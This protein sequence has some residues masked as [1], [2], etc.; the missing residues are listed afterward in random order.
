M[1]KLLRSWV[2]A[3]VLGAMPLGAW[4]QLVVPINPFNAAAS[5]TDGTRETM[6]GTPAIDVI[7]L[8]AVGPG[9]PLRFGNVIPS[10]ER[11]TLNG[12]SLS[13]GTEYALDYAAGVMYLKVAQK[14]GD[15]LT[16]SYRYGEKPVGNTVGV[17][18]GFAGMKFD[19]APGGLKMLMG[20]GIA[21]RAADGS[22]M[23]SNVYGVNNTMKFAGGKV[24]GLFLVGERSR[25]DN[26][27]GLTFAAQGGGQASTQEQGNSSLIVQQFQSALLGGEFEAD[28]QDVSKNFAAF[29]QVRDAGYDQ[30]TVDAMAKERGLNRFSAALRN[31]KMGGGLSFG[32]AFKTVGEGSSGIEWRSMNLAQGDVTKGNGLRLQV[33]SQKVDGD[34]NRIRDLREGDREQLLKERGMSRESLSGEIA[35]QFGKLSFSS[36]AV[37]DDA[38]GQGILR[39]EVTLDTARLKLQ[40]GDQD[41]D[42]GFGRMG[43]LL[44]QEQALYGRELGMRRQWLALESSIL[45]KN[46]PFA[47]NQRLLGSDQ[48][49][50][51]AREASLKGGAWSLNHASR[52]ADAGF[53]QIGAMSD[54]EIDGNLRAIAKMYGQNVEVRPEDRS[55]FFGTAGIGREYTRLDAQPFKGWNASF[56]HLQ[57]RGQTDGAKVSNLTVTGPKASLN[58][59]HQQVGGDFNEITRLMN[60]E[61][62][63]MGQISGM[64]R[65]DANASFN[66]GK[67]RDA[68]A[69]LLQAKTGTE[70][71]GRVSA[72]YND[73]KI[74]V[75]M[76]ARQVDPNANVGGL[77]DPERDLLASLRGFSQHDVKVRWQ[78]LPS[79]RVD[80]FLFD[81]GNT[82]TDEERRIRNAIIDWAPDKKTSLNYTR[83]EN[84]S[85]DPTGMLFSQLVER[86]S[87]NRDLGKYGALSLLRERHQ[88]EG[89]KQLHRVFGWRKGERPLQHHQYRSREERGRER[90]RYAR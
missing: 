12:R 20:F 31:V 47:F 82:V 38:S 79:M 68:S 74:N 85:G 28:Y 65:L 40:A 22:V 2:G 42:A 32:T 66:L 76:A 54:A 37:Q 58:V 24:A 61:R 75:T 14:A 89:R 44:G 64:S 11:V 84:R 6:G 13:R 81:A 19:I 9:T 63:R 49:N 57:L 39:R 78:I 73:P 60:F 23:L 35:R 5:P 34:F 56:D 62:Q 53:G 16:V 52:R 33:S 77:V 71:V 67:G 46:T 88:Y 27:S 86:M 83:L 51:V 15:S 72:T 43:S 10:S 26:R 59:R 45:G 41:V 55:F 1:V 30:A 80:A 21:E 17:A 18:N 25:Q 69:S 8:N 4:A 36:T 3:M 90:D 50:H 48:G 29:S 87:I 7:R 70:G